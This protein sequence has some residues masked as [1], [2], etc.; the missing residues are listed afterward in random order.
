[1]VYHTVHSAV[2]LSDAPTRGGP[3]PDPEA[4][5]HRQALA[6]AKPKFP[7]PPAASKKTT[8]AMFEAVGKWRRQSAEPAAAAP[9][10]PPQDAPV[11]AAAAPAVSRPDLTLPAAPPA[12]A[13][14]VLSDGERPSGCEG[15]GM[16]DVLCG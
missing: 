13:A 3:G 12:R 9:E 1:M 2:Q 8:A 6:S 5:K 14:S 10:G 11:A 4:A 7:D 15:K 16:P